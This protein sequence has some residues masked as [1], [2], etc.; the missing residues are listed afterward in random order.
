M[1]VPH[2]TVAP[3]KVIRAHAATLSDCLVD[4]FAEIEALKHQV[5]VIYGDYASMAVLR[6]HEREHI[7]NNALWGARLTESPLAPDHTFVIVGEVVKPE[8]DLS[9][10][11]VHV[12]MIFS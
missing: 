12:T 8:S 2:V 4:G 1:Q 9:S 7:E 5:R 11:V 6:E 3:C 10:L